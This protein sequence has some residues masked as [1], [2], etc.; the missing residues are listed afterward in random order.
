MRPVKA[1]RQTTIKSAGTVVTL[2][3]EPMVTPFALVRVSRNVSLGVM[4]CGHD[5]GS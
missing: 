3:T 5:V 1:Q 4:E 2:Q